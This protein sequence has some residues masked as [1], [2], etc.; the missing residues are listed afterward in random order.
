VRGIAAVASTVA[1]AACSS[2]AAETMFHDR[3]IGE[4]VQIVA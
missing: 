3:S 2:G 4:V 1:P